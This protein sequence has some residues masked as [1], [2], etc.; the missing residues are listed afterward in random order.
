[1]RITSI[2]VGL[3]REVV[4]KGQEVSTGIFKDP[5]TGPVEIGTLNLAGDAQADLTVHGGPDKAVYVYPTEHYDYWR[6]ELPGVSLPWGKFGENFTVEGLAQGMPA[7]N[8]LAEDAV[9]I[10]DTFRIGSA[11]LMVTQPRMPCY[12]LG[13]KFRRDDIIKRFL[14]S[15]RSGFYLKVIAPGVASVGAEVVPLDRDPNLVTVADIGRLYLNKESHPDLLGRA[16]KVGALP[17]AW[18]DWLPQ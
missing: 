15:G 6:R 16:M 10:G 18:K 8:G 9:Y 2:N 17:Q 12:K 13:L 14:L 4:W 3:P 1:V 5:V 7:A 11:I